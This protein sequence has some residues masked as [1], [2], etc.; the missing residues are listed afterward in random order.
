[1][2]SA[3]KMIEAER[4]RQ[5]RVHRWSQRHDDSH[6]KG[7]LAMAAACYVTPT[8]YRNYVYR[9]TKGMPRVPKLW[10]WDH[11]WWK[12]AGGDRI[13]ELVKAGALIAAK[14]ERLKRADRKKAKAKSSKK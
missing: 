12:P 10:P 13:R 9:K 4:N 7:E 6:D 14:I 3:I 5:K 1:M 11:E 2:S 8:P